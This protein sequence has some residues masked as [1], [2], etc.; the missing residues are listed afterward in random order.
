MVQFCPVKSA[1]I[2]HEALAAAAPAGAAEV[3]DEQ[4]KS[5]LLLLRSTPG[6]S[7]RFTSGWTRIS[8]RAGGSLRIPAPESESKVRQVGRSDFGGYGDL[9]DELRKIERSKRPKSPPMA[10]IQRRQTGADVLCPDA[11][12]QTGS[13][14]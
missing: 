3:Q 12:H 6:L 13:E 7:G 14:R 11:S 8:A 2:I 10:G 1:R 5:V 9:L 4:V